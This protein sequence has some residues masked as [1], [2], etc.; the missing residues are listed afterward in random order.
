MKTNTEAEPTLSERAKD[1]IAPPPPQKSPS[2]A[3]LCFVLQQQSIE[4]STLAEVLWDKTE[5]RS[6]S[7]KLMSFAHSMG[8]AARLI[9]DLASAHLRKAKPQRLGKKKAARSARK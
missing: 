3:H 6:L 4:A 9:D 8:K 7:S 5:S 2:S 1:A